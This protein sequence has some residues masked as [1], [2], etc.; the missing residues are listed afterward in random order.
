MNPYT[1]FKVLLCKAS[2]GINNLED[3]EYMLDIIEDFP[4]LNTEEITFLHNVDISGEYEKDFDTYLDFM[5]LC[6]IQSFSSRNEIGDELLFLLDYYK[7]DFG[8][9]GEFGYNV[10]EDGLLFRYGIQM[11]EYHL[12]LDKDGDEY[13]VNLGA[14]A[15][16]LMGYYL[17]YDVNSE[18]P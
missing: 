7:D 14:E 16:E 13:Y 4:D 5:S 8:L 18:E 12:K 15:I 10:V 1:F 11:V 9:K 2:K 17:D 6:Y 3:K